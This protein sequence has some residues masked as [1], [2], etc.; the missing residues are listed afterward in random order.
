MAATKIELEEVKKERGSYKK[1]LER[2]KL[3]KRLEGERW[4]MVVPKLDKANKELRSG[5]NSSLVRTINPENLNSM[6]KDV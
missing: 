6:L 4:L 5:T 2:E 3:W 1:S